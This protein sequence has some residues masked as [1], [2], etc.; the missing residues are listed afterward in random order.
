MDFLPLRPI[1]FPPLLKQQENQLTENPK[2]NSTNVCRYTL[3]VLE[4]LG[5]GHA[6][7]DELIIS[8]VNNTLTAAGKKSSIRS[9]KVKRPPGF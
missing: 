5:Q 9:F 3:N 6:A 4:N 1:R 7:G 8:W 2:V